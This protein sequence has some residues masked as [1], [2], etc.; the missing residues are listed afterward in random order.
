MINSVAQMQQD[1][2]KIQEQAK[3]ARLERLQK[4][5]DQNLQ[6]PA[7]FPLDPKGFIQG[8]QDA[9]QS[10]AGDL[11]LL[12]EEQIKQ[13]EFGTILY[14][15]KTGEAVIARLDLIPPERFN[16]FTRWGTRR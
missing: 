11:Y 1:F 2:K 8:G 5:A 12:T 9:Y 4:Y 3:L 7:D 14:D 10:R 6:V 13:L 15:F 16:G